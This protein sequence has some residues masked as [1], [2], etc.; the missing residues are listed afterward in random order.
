MTLNINRIAHPVRL[1]TGN[2]L[3][4]QETDIALLQKVT[5]DRIN[6]IPNYTAY[7]NTGTDLSGTAILTRAGILLTDVKRLPNGRGKADLFQTAWIVNIYAPSGTEKR[8][9]GTFLRN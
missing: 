9:E 5:T 7:V 2:L 3:R 8:E 4:Q 1:D 6:N